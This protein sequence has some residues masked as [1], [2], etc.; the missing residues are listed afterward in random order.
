VLLPKVAECRTC[1]IGEQRTGLFAPKG[2]VPSGCAMCHV[3]HP[4]G[5]APPLSR[6]RKS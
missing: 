2:K 5:A 3:Y 1:H 6:H 4:T